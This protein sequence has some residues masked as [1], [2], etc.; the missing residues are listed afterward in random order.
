MAMTLRIDDELDQA[1]TEL[2]AAEGTSKQEVIKRA[3]IERRDR[4][5]RRELINRIAN[6]ALV[7]YADALE[8]LGK[9]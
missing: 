4:T 1:L 8:R 9:A 6:E 5:V 3:V 7:E 2:A